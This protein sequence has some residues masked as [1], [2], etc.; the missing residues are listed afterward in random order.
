[1][2]Y[3]GI[4]VKVVIMNAHKFD[5]I[6][7]ILLHHLPVNSILLFTYAHLG[8]LFKELTGFVVP[9]RK[10]GSTEFKVTPDL[11]VN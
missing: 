11:Q 10:V 7:V 2:G 8:T 1:M 9:K 4:E 3:V 6:L 5:F